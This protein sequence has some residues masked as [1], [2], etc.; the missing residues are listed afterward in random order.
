MQNIVNL[1]TNTLAGFSQR[2]SHILA[3]LI[4]LKHM[5]ELINE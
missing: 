4:I 2:G 1:K 3:L 5:N